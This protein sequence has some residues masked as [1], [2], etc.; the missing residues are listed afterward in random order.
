MLDRGCLTNYN[1][2]FYSAFENYC[3]GDYLF[4]LICVFILGERVSQYISGWCE[5]P[6]V[7]RSGKT[8]NLEQSSCPCLSSGKISGFFWYVC[9]Q[10]VHMEAR[11]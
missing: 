1:L 3:L 2:S 10:S 6:C 7:C 9:S 4:I 11:G 8:L 5:I